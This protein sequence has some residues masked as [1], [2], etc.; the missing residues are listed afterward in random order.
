VEKGEYVR[1]RGEVVACGALV[2]QKGVVIRA[3]EIALM[4]S[5]GVASL[6][7]FRSPRVA[8]LSTGDELVD[9][10]QP[11]EPHQIYNSN[12]YGLSAQ[13]ASAGGVPVMLGIAKDTRDDL[14]AK[15]KEVSDVDF[16]LISGGV[17]AGDYDFVKE[18]IADLG[19]TMKF[20]KV[21]MKP[22]QP[23]AFGMI[24]GKPIFG[25]PGNPVSAMVA[26]DQFVRPALLFAQGG[27]RLFYP[28]LYA[29]LTEKIKKD[30]GR[31]HF[32]RGNLTCE[33]GAYRV[34]PTGD[35]DSS[36]LTSLVKANGF[37]VLPEQSGDVVAGERV[38]VQM[39]ADSL[40]SFF[41]EGA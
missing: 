34:A 37:I 13:V 14:S 40:I 7:V 8:I 39:M 25:L 19:A 24:S 2:L 27:S 3:Y 16:I 9:I 18:V 23:L 35:Q 22:G 1:Y 20:W 4:A 21:A 6:S 38:L 10:H 41:S 32:V 36:H 5:I 33:H 17:S 12:G 11:K 15:I 28:T 31:C 29:T 30:P 26:F